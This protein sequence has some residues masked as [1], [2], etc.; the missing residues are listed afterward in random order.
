MLLYPRRQRRVEAGGGR[1]RGGPSR[2]SV[3]RQVVAAEDRERAGRAIAPD[4]Q[5]GRD[6]VERRVLAGRG[7]LGIPGLRDGQRED[8][9][10]RRGD[11]LRDRRVLSIGGVHEARDRADDLRRR[12]AV[13]LLDQRVEVVLAAQG[14]GHLGVPLEQPE[15]DD[16]PVAARRRQLVGV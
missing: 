9:G 2:V 10:L 12:L 6:A 7:R 14:R 1:E 5:R 4:R 16:P 3:A 11:Q 13:A 15:A 8:R